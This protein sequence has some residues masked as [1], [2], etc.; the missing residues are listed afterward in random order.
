MMDWRRLM[1]PERFRGIQARSGPDRDRE[2]RSLRSPFLRDFDRIVYSSAFRRL[3]DKTQVYP[4]PDTDYVRTRLTHSIE[5]SSVGRSLGLSVGQRL[6]QMHKLDEPKDGGLALR[7][8]DFGDV[9]AAA[10]LAHDIGHPPFGHAGEEAIRHWFRVDR[11]DLL[12][13]GCT[14]EETSDLAHFES[15]AQGFRVVTRLQFWRQH[16]GMQLCCATLGAFTKYPRG[17]SRPDAA[18]GR[19]EPR[20]KF[21]YCQQDRPAFEEIAGRLGLLPQ[22]GEVDAWCRHPLAYLVEAADDIAYLIVDIEDGFKSGRV[23]F[24][25]VEDVLMRVA[26]PEAGSDRDLVD[27]DDRIGYLRA[28][29]IGTLIE[30]TVEAFCA[31]EA[32]LRL[33]GPEI[34]L[35]ERIDDREVVREVRRLCQERL[36][37]DERKL[38]AEIA[39]FAVVRGL[40]EFYTDAV[41]ALERVGYAIDRTAYLYRKTLRALPGLQNVPHRRYDWLLWVTDYVSGM[42]DRFAVSQYK[43]VRGFEV[44]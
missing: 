17:S 43:M 39:G 22:S 19:C 35:L 23:P 26:G 27:E 20:E 41:I 8:S 25:E 37:N 29:A 30:R 2:G 28:K 15:N 11:P 32:D 34:P 44:G 7:P 13:E 1:S 31:H 12:R 24:K 4:F 10:C 14:P 42:T 3:Q 5:V 40:L 18:S 9:V 33:G 21:G 6:V 36:Y 38:K 16:G